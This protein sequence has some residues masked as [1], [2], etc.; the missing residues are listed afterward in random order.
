MK[1]PQRISVQGFTLLELLISLVIFSLIAAMAYG[2][3]NNIL[4][5]RSQTEAKVQKLY[6][7]QMALTLMERDVE[8]AVD[9]PARDGYGDEKPALV[10]N[11]YGDYLLEFTR[12]GWLN[13]LN[14]PRS[15]LLWWAAA[16]GGIFLVLIAAGAYCVYPQRRKTDPYVM[17]CVGP[18]AGQRALRYRDIGR[19]Q[20]FGN[21]LSGCQ[22]R[23]ATLLA[24]A[25]FVR[26]NTTTRSTARPA[27]RGNAGCAKT[28]SAWRDSG[29]VGNQGIRKSRAMVSCPR[30]N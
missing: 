29:G 24:T 11:E 10:G 1:Q 30:I 5:A 23:M 7:L 9:R 20:E 16:I 25:E 21:P 4:I 18:C 15:H 19:R 3:L 8:Q 27:A 28:P 6:Q 22:W 14:S 17:V 12:T 2:A 13:P 26:H